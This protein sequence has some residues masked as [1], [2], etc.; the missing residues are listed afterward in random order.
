MSSWIFD[1][2]RI[3]T[4]LA[5]LVV[6][7]LAAC[8]GRGL[9][10]IAAKPSPTSTIQVAGK[11]LVIAGPP[12]FCMDKT[13]SQIDFDTAFVLLGNCAVVAPGTNSGQPKIKALLT[14]SV[15][16]AGGGI[17]GITNSAKDMD[18]FFRSETGR[19]ALSRV[20][21]PGTVTILDSFENDGAYYLRATDTSPGIV[22][23]ASDEYW[24][25]YFDLNGQL[26]S[27]SAIGFN[28]KPL[29]AATGLDTVRDFTGAMRRGNGVAP[30]VVDEPVQ[31]TVQPTVQ[32]TIRRPPPK[33]GLRGIG[34]LRRLFG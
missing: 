9:G 19:T 32:P 6:T 18:R 4:I 2:R 3:K 27:L 30:L 15:S 14:A 25:A 8:G 13:A 17:S 5:L 7:G 20:S 16:G 29:S 11:S 1:P 34:I 31:T 22:P 33:G 12:G 26:V 28:D 21:D 23:D 24:R 10:T